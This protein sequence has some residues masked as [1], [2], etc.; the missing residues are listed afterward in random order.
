MLDWEP[1]SQQPFFPSYATVQTAREARQDV[2]SDVGCNMPSLVNHDERI[3]S[4][5]N[6][7]AL[8]S[9]VALVVL[10]LLIAAMIALLVSFGGF[11]WSAFRDFVTV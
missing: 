6:R 2:L 5:V 7:R 11:L 10:L 9:A 1:W 4:E 3:I 8:Q